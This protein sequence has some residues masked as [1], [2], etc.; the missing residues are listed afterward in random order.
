[1]SNLVK[2]AQI[3]ERVIGIL[4]RL[5]DRDTF[6]PAVQDLSQLVTTILDADQAATMISCLSQNTVEPKASTRREMVL[7]FGK[8]VSRAFQRVHV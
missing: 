2:R 6:L 3:K 4:T 8:Y 7:A 5:A 1:M